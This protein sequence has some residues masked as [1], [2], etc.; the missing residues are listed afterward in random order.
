MNN[1]NHEWSPSDL[2]CVVH[3]TKIKWSGM[4]LLQV[5]SLELYV[6]PN[7]PRKGL[8]AK[9]NF[10]NHHRPVIFFANA[11]AIPIYYLRNYLRDNE[12]FKCFL[13]HKIESFYAVYFY[14]ICLEIEHNIA[15]EVFWPKIIFEYTCKSRASHVTNIKSKA[16]S[17]Y[18][19]HTFLSPTSIL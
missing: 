9:K 5:I 2:G 13:L 8:T 11:M 19:Q 16:P 18:H 1:P 10:K 7:S 4:N 14:C 3:R 6:T 17:H 15:S 12:S